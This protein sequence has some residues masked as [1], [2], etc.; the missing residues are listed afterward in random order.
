MF[1]SSELSGVGDTLLGVFPASFSERRDQGSELGLQRVALGGLIALEIPQSP[2]KVHLEVL[3]AAS[4]QA[5]MA[6]S[7]YS[8]G[9][10]CSDNDCTA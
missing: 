8:P 1:P 2:R 5:R 6:R 10:E 9:S 3:E 7:G 4:H